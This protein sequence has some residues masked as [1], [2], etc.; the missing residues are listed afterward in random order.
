[1]NRPPTKM[2]NAISAE[3]V[4]T[5]GNSSSMKI[6][7]IKSPMNRTALDTLKKLRI[8]WTENA[9]WLNF[10]IALAFTNQRTQDD[11]TQGQTESPVL[12]W[13]SRQRVE[14]G[15]SDQRADH[16]NRNV[17]HTFGQVVRQTQVPAVGSF[18]DYDTDFAT[19]C[20]ARWN[21]FDERDEHQQKR[22]AGHVFDHR[23]CFQRNVLKSDSFQVKFGK[24]WVAETLICFA[25]VIVMQRA[26]KDGDQ[27]APDQFQYDYFA[28]SQL[29]AKRPIDQDGQ[30]AKKRFRIVHQFFVISSDRMIVARTVRV[31]SGWFQMH[32]FRMFFRERKRKAQQKVTR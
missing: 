23:L 29:I 18:F 24:V 16:L 1:M 8:N 10:G 20:Q 31:R 3:M 25:R 7:P 15:Q 13:L 6:A 17:D 9:T 4:R 27:N 26:Q 30:M 5:A 28:C 19:E 21:R 32:T 2:K 12:G 22:N 11:C 14:D